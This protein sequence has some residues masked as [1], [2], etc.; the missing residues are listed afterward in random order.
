MNVSF[1]FAGRTT[2]SKSIPG[3]IKRL[4]W[5]P[6]KEDIVKYDLLKEADK[7]TMPVL[8]IVGDKDKSTPLEHQKILF[9]H[10]PG[11]KKELHVIE[12]AP[13]TFRDKEQLKEIKKIMKEWIRKW[14][15]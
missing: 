12:G 7:L 15:R 6:F 3:L 4:K 2:V 5:V 10:I 11:D 1:I 9:E 13:H 14:L 8:I